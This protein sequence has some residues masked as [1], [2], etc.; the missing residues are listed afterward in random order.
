VAHMVRLVDDLLELSRISRGQIELKKETLALSTIVEHAVEASRPFIEEHHHHLE[1]NLPAEQFMVDGD[2]VRLS[3][4]FANLLNNAAKYT[5]AGGRIRLSAHKEGAMVCVSVCDTGIGIPEDMLGRVFEMFTQVENV[6][7]G[8]QDG[9]GI[10]LS[11]VQSLV[12]MHGGS[13]ECR[14]G[15]LGHGS[16]FIVR[17]ALADAPKLDVAS[18]ERPSDARAAPPDAMRVLVADDNEDSADS[19]G[20]L[21]ELL[22]MEVKVTYDGQSALDALRTY[23]P[24]V[25]ILD[26][27]MPGLD[28]HEVARRVRR[29]PALRD[30]KLIALTG[31]GQEEDRRRTREAGFDHHFVK[32]I[33]FE[34]LKA[35]LA[36]WNTQ[37]ACEEASAVVVSPPCS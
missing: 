2:L 35:L 21:L 22:H 24:T 34:A 23:H 15:G 5:E 19:L 27:G 26:V 11:L 7:H 1:V 32:P 10:G 30:V 16:E 12:R 18:S 6:L 29:D 36:S 3:Q 31:W 37:S 25:M 8:S 14:S 33:D 28:G 4:V 20:M 17:L 13:V 9:L